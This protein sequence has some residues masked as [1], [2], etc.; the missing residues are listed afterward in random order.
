[1]V[2]K[3]NRKLGAAVCLLLALKF[4]E[5]VQCATEARTLLPTLMFCFAGL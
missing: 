4:N 5:L 2:D 1:M 3:V